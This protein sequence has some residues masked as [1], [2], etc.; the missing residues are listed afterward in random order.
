MRF[1]VTG[2]AGFIGS[3]LTQKLLKLGHNVLG[4][5][6][7]LT[8][9]ADNI[10]AIRDSLTYSNKKLFQFI[11]QDVRT[12][13]DYRDIDAVFHLAALG[14]V[15]RSVKSPNNTHRVNVDGT[16]KVLNSARKHAVPR[17]VLSSSSSV[18]GDHIE[19]VKEESALGRQI[20]PYSASK[21][22]NEL[23]AEAFR[24]SYGMNIVCL[25]YFNVYGPRQ[26]T[27]G[28]YAAVIPKWI[29]AMKEKHEITIYGDGEQSRDFTFV[30]DVVRANIGAVHADLE[31][32]KTSGS[33]YN[34]GTG[35]STSLNELF[36]MLAHRL[37][38]PHAPTYSKERTGDRKHSCAST[39]LA[40]WALGFSAQTELEEGI[41]KTLYGNPS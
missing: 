29:Q 24:A 37:E 8:G 31:I 21:R 30:E 33:V 28:P 14:S 7:F 13:D 39:T 27:N 22:M 17:V 16:F 12:F 10:H 2:C 11:D 23:A 20:S 25:R 18:Y 36:V 19:I 3:H 40:A 38:Y 9:S 26:R 4:V 41:S 32:L 6:N 5:D 15:P 34:V 35:I 1:L